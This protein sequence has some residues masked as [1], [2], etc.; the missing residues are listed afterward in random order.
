M[1]PVLV[2]SLLA[3]AA[4]AQAQLRLPQLPGVQRLP[5]VIDRTVDRVVQ[6]L[7]E[8]LS[9]TT[10]LVDLRTVQLRDLL[11]RHPDVVEADPRGELIRRRELVLISPSDAALAVAASLGLVK[12]REEAWPELDLREVVMRVPAGVDTADA[13]EQLRAAQPDLQADF[14]HLYSRSGDVSPGSAAGAPV[15]QTGPIRVGLI[16]GGVDRRHAALRHAAGPSFGCGGSV[17]R[18]EHGTAVA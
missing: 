7:P 10:Q 6:P 18:S 3:A 4:A 2:L 15:K 17:V 5:G 14:N 12:L 16:D 9:S 1:K 13:L 8:L 11:R